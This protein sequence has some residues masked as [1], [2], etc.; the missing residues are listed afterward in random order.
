MA[1]STF[2]PVIIPDCN[3]P[4]QE[5]LKVSFAKDISE[6]LL[7]ARLRGVYYLVSAAGKPMR[8]LTPEEVPAIEDENYLLQHDLL[9]EQ[10]YSIIIDLAP[11]YTYNFSLILSPDGRELYCRLAQGSKINRDDQSIKRFF[12]RIRIQKANMHVLIRD[13]KKEFERLKL[14]IQSL[15]DEK[16][17]SKPYEFLLAHSVGGQSCVEPHLEMAISLKET[18]PHRLVLKDQLIA[19]FVKGRSGEA[20]RDCLGRFIPPQDP[21][22]QDEVPFSIDESIKIEESDESIKYFA[23]HSGY[24]ALDKTNNRLGVMQKI[25][26]K[27]ASLST[28]GHFL[29]GFNQGTHL[30]ITSTDLLEDT[31]GEGLIVEAGTVEIIGNVGNKATIRANKVIIK[32][33]THQNA[34]ILGDDIDITIHK[35]LA[36]GENVKISR[37]EAGIAKGEKVTIEHAYGGKSFG[38]HVRLLTLHANHHAYGSSSITIN[39]LKGED[40]KFILCANASPKKDSRYQI[41]LKAKKQFAQQIAQKQREYSVQMTELKKLQPFILQIKDEIKKY[42]QNSKRRKLIQE[43]AGNYKNLL[44]HTKQLKN[45]IDTL[46]NKIDKIRLEI[47][48]LEESMGAAFVLAKNGWKGFNEV[49]FKNLSDEKEIF[50][51]PV[52]GRDG[53]RVCLD[54]TMSILISTRG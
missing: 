23:Q 18:H 38:E 47:A 53:P 12:E 15:P 11:R 50:L 14:F 51:K 28:T 16:F 25:S 7:E 27:N 36:E 32:G 19:T 45:E 31:V 43:Q 49:C 46:A 2:S 21:Q 6:Q 41:F 17:L 8:E 20:A 44:H 54:D 3:A 22:N 48:K 29:G 24:I 42:Q 9:I 35:G 4:D 37:L 52:A 39:N 30:V 40:N 5:L 1:A 13:E 34:T 33:Q 10:R 26:V